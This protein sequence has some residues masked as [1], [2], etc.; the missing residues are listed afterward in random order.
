MIIGVGELFSS[1]TKLPEARSSPAW[2]NPAPMRSGF[3]PES[4]EEYEN[5]EYA[6][7][8]GRTTCCLRCVGGFALC[9]AR[10][11]RAVRAAALCASF[12]DSTRVELDKHLGHTVTVTGPRTYESKAPEK[13]E[14]VVKASSKE[15]YANL[16]VTGLKMV[17][18]TCN[19]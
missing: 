18:E 9:H 13:R 11:C 6:I 5:L 14:G 17:S 4:R 12:V 2:T 1:I 19:K 10:R 16:A 8:I 3:R 15:E 7:Q